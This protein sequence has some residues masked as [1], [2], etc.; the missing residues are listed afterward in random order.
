ME[1]HSSILIKRYIYMRRL[2]RGQTKRKSYGKIADK[3]NAEGIPTKR[4]KQWTASGVFNIIN[5]K[6]PSKRCS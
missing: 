6:K 2:S 5:R 1:D 4:Q 3:L